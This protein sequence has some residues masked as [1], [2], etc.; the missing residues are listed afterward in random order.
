MPIFD[1]NFLKD[2]LPLYILSIMEK[3]K[4]CLK[5]IIKFCETLKL[6]GKS[7]W[8]SIKKKIIKQVKFRNEE[9]KYLLHSC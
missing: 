8:H 2:C 5:I 3:G 7:K 1:K 4:D 6:N 9:A